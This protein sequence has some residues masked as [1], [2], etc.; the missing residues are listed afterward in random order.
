MDRPIRLQNNGTPNGRVYLD[1]GKTETCHEQS[2]YDEEATKYAT[3]PTR[4]AKTQRFGQ[5]KQVRLTGVTPMMVLL[6][7]YC[8][9]FVMQY[10]MP[11]TGDAECKPYRVHLQTAPVHILELL[12]G[13]GPTTADKIIEYR[14]EHRIHTPDDLLA[15]HGIGQKTVDSLRSLTTEHER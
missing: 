4:F 10:S 3:R 5:G 9:Y 8:F 11:M 2:H 7:A 1:Q 14:K 6:L 15:I 12:P 13:V